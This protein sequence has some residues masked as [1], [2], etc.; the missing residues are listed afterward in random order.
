MSTKLNDNLFVAGLVLA[1]LVFS[2]AANAQTDYNVRNDLELRDVLKL[3]G[4]KH[5]VFIDNVIV[6]SP[7][8]FTVNDSKV[9][10]DLGKYNFQG[11]DT[12]I[13]KGNGEVTIKGSTTGFNGGLLLQE[14]ITL[15]YEGIYS[16]SGVDRFG[17]GPMDDVKVNL[18]R[19]GSM[20]NGSTLP[21]P[22]IAALADVRDG[23]LIIGDRGKATM[24]VYNG[25]IVKN[26][27]TILGAY[28]G[29]DGSLNLTGDDVDWFTSGSF[30]V[31]YGG[32]GMLNISGGVETKTGSIVVGK[33]DTANGE[34]KISGQGTT[35]NLYGREGDGSMSSSGK[36]VMNLTDG[37]LLN[38]DESKT[39]LGDLSGYAPKLGLGEGASIV[40]N[41]TVFGAITGPAG[42]SLKTGTIIGHPGGS[43][44]FQ[45]GS[46]LE[47]S[48]D[49]LVGTNTFETGSVI[50]PGEHQDNVV[51]G[52]INFQNKTFVHKSTAATY[53]DFN[54]HGVEG[55]SDPNNVYGVTYLGDGGRD[56]LYITGDALLAGDVYFRP[57]SG[58]Y[59]DDIDVR[60]M[61]LSGGAI[62][63]QYE[64]MTVTP[65]RWFRNPT[66]ELNGGD[67]HFKAERN[68]TPFT[69]VANSKNLR[70]VGN[71]L[72]DIYNAQDNVE[73][74]NVLDWVWLMND[75]EL[76]GAMRQLAGETR[77]NS[78]LMPLR[79]PWKFVF[80]RTDLGEIGRNQQEQQ[81]DCGVF[82]SHL[83]KTVKNDLWAAPFY[84]YFHA[85]FDD[86]ASATTN[87]Q[88][89]V[90]VGYDKALSSKSTLGFL[91][92]Y[93][94]SDLKQLYSR[95]SADDFLFGLH[96]NTLLQQRYE[97]KLWGSYG[98]Q[99]YRLR[100]EL[101]LPEQDGRTTARYS[102]NT[103][104]LS[105]QIAMPLKWR[106]TV[107][108]PFAALDLN[109]VQQNSATEQGY[110]AIALRYNDACWTQ[111]SG[112]VG[113]R[114]DY[115]WRRWESHASL[116]YAL[117]F[118]GNEAPTVKN[119]FIAGG[120]SFKIQGTDLGRHFVNF[121][122][123]GHRW[124][125]H[126]KTR[127]LFV[128]Y[129]GEYGKN[130]NEQTVSLGYQ[131]AF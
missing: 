30:Y 78:F 84:D 31:G 41:S 96:Y 24:N 19:E 37:A 21:G 108:R 7:Y 101:P 123:G 48:L 73:W 88:L 22:Y 85:S 104:A 5:I 71:S 116:S 56:T 20:W 67:N 74:L 86:N 13:F 32:K 62:T 65:S 114:T 53:I 64:N 80:D 122:L 107:L 87:S 36:G 60:F 90:L 121:G 83:T 59:S 91:F 70:G 92:A 66:L 39:R 72:N 4:D 14:R 35:V 95:V 99:A 12:A 89:G 120:Q 29:G 115:V 112:R 50:T 43:L 27:E 45:N 124:L 63:G 68:E 103:V 1:S 61:Q 15:N 118:A 3:P 2:V 130:S 34:L 102:G 49:I 111:L 42:Q 54:V 51:F 47:G 17:T 126:Q 94:D 77:A 8:D 46:T 69:D 119:Q 79:S 100:R 6:E 28:A 93:S 55:F 25:N 10:I 110:E 113:V 38:F 129:N 57:Q 125:D 11:N 76:R 33:E 26:S 105:S 58:Y 52:R 40:N 98:T 117:M 127:M 75:N 97:L 81:R 82:R 9:S 18:K 109:V 131:H 106:T 44:T 16:M 23:T 128:Q